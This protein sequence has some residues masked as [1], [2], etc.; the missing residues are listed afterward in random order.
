[1]G[2]FPNSRIGKVEFYEA[3][4]DVW[5]AA[6]TSIGLTA[7]QVT[8]LETATGNAR[9]AYEEQ[10]AAID[11]AKAATLNFYNC[12]RLM[13]N[14]PGKGADMV[15]TIRTFAQTTNNPNVYVLAQIP[16]PATP[17]TTPPPGTPNTFTVNLLETGALE[18]KWKCLN[19]E[20][21]SGTIYEVRRNGQFIGA[22][23]IKSFTD[24]TLPGTSPV[25]Y[26][27]TAVRSTSRGNP[28]Q[29]TVT[30]GTGGG[31]LAITSV[32]GGN[33]TVGVKMAA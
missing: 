17:G 33:T 13:H 1:M 22:S 5:A 6:P 30:F 32:Q 4:V 9:K 8:A 15:Q 20:G 18:L 11:A 14:A 10:L 2:T 27:V 19:P 26:Q 29:F 31:G 12:V 24:D 7:A 28:A 16:P 25:V 3:H 21:V 23:G